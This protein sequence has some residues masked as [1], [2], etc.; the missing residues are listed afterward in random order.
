MNKI[1]LEIKWLKKNNLPYDWIIV[2]EKAKY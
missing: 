2:L 1:K